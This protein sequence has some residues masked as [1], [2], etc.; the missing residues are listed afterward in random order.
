MKKASTGSQARIEET[1]GA[2]RGTS[3]QRVVA[4]GAR[5]LEAHARVQ[6]LAERLAEEID[7]VT[8]PHGI[9]TTA[10]DQEDSMVIA[11]EKAI[12]TT[13]AT[14][15]PPNGNGLAA[16]PRPQMRLGIRKPSKG[17]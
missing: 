10:L 17:G 3:T 13:R 14:T 15:P 16:H 11:V 8:S 9:P 2:R 5:A 1:D 4:A 7:N 12:V 6:R